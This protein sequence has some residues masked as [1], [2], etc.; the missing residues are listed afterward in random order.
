MHFPSYRKF[1]QLAK[2]AAKGKDSFGVPL[3]NENGPSA[4]SH[5]ATGGSKSISSHSLK[6]SGT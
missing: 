2:T 6:K 1:M 4:R 5:A 3:T